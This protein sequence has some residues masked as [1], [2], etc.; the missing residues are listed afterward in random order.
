MFNILQ[1]NVTP[2][3]FVFSVTTPSPDFLVTSER[4]HTGRGSPSLKVTFWRHSRMTTCVF[5]VPCRENKVDLKCL[6]IK[7]I[8]PSS[9]HTFT[10]IVNINIWLCDYVVSDNFIAS[11]RLITAVFFVFQAM[12]IS[13]RSWGRG[14]GW[15]RRFYLR[16]MLRFTRSPAGTESWRSRL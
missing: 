13:R 15:R 1:V 12:I 5:S 3:R 8:S 10:R 9:H 14:P 16:W 11:L 2:V 7:W 4:T 6:D